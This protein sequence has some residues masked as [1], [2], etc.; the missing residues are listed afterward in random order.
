M[1]ANPPDPSKRAGAGGRRR[2]L[3]APL[4][5]LALVVVAA[6]GVLAVRQYGGMPA[7][8]AAETPAR[9]STLSIGG[10]FTLVDQDGRTVTNADFS[11]RWLLVYFGFTFCPDVCPTAL[12]RNADAIDLLGEQGEQVT[13]VLI[14]V[15]PQRDTPEKLK[16][17]VHFFHPRTVGLTGTPQQIA[18]VAKE[19]RVFYAKSPGNTPE[20]YLIDHSSLTYL[21][22]PDGK[23]VEFFSHG[24]SAEEMA[25]RIKQRL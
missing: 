10:P 25:N 23:F 24:T 14:S 5:A 9:Q 16:E 11:G 4:L 22:G 13:P 20:T 8:I 12:S 3:K 17:Y 2:R 18:A 7:G 19:Y 15:D 1:S 21:I 6:V